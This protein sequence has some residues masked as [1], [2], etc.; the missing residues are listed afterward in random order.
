M[1]LLLC[2]FCCPGCRAEEMVDSRVGDLQL[3]LAQSEQTPE[4][5][6]P[7]HPPWLDHFKRWLARRN[8]PHFSS[9]E[10]ASAMIEQEV[11]DATAPAC[12]GMCDVLLY[13]RWVTKPSHRLLVV[14]LNAATSPVASCPNRERLQHLN[15]RGLLPPEE[16]QR[17]EVI[18]LFTTFLEEFPFD[19]KLLHNLS[20]GGEYFRALATY[21]GGRGT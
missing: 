11:N 19:K 4:P 21:Y 3:S 14:L 18:E 9:L 12:R 10:T 13:L 8:R 20:P 5:Q 7:I 1:L 2:F 17:H 16:F 6:T 15:S